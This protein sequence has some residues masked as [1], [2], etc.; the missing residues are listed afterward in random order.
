[1]ENYK[2]QLIDLTKC[3]NVLSTGLFYGHMGIC[4]SLYLMNKTFKSEEIENLADKHL[5][6]VITDIARMKDVSFDCGLAG[7]GWAIN[8]LHTNCCIK[9]KID[10]ILFEIDALLYRNLCKQNR[11]FQCDLVNGLTGTLVYFVYRLKY[12]GN[13]IS[14][15]QRSII[16][17]ALQIIIDKLENNVPP[18]FTNLSKDLYSSVLWDFPILFFYLGESMR[19]GIY[20]DKIMAMLNSWS[21]LFTGSL[22]FLHIN[23]LSLANSLAYINLELNNRLV[24]KYVDTLF[25]SI[26]FDDYICEIDRGS[27]VLNGDWFCALFNANRALHLMNP[28]HVRFYALETVYPE[29]YKLYCKNVKDKLNEFSLNPN[30]VSLINGLCGSMLVYYYFKE[31]NHSPSKTELFIL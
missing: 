11:I 8:C 20:K 16:Q 24:E 28:N 4:L 19:L 26:N 6:K 5:D 1:M 22:P 3:E 23:R 18:K 21:Y 10:E 17:T 12:K 29:L 13:N 27:I 14:D 25:Y 9:G 30:N 15:I 7:I 2:Q 31:L